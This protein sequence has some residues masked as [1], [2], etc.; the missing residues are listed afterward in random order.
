M[1]MRKASGW[2]SQELERNHG[3]APPSPASKLLPGTQKAGR[4]LENKN[5]GALYLHTYIYIKRCGD[6]DVTYYV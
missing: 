6:R 3:K 5:T 2:A 1:D 4:L